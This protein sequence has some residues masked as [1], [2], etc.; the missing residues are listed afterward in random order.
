MSF[1]QICDLYYLSNSILELTNQKYFF[2]KTFYFLQCYST[3][4]KNKA[5]LEVNY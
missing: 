4:N 2:L 1:K 5:R 3:I